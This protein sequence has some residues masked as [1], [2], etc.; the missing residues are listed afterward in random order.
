MQMIIGIIFLILALL[1]MFLGGIPIGVCF[2]LSG[3]LG[4]IAVRGF[5]AALS[6]L[7][8]TT[9]TWTSTEGLIPLPLFILMG[10]FAFHSGITS[11]LFDTANKWL[12]R[13][14]GG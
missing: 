13:F 3:F 9:Y 2:G 5:D 6:I 14:P 12:G 10:F 4:L 1:L 8:S 7:A 11:E